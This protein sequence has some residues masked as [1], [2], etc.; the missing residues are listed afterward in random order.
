MR[1]LVAQGKPLAITGWGTATWRGAADVAPRSNEIV[2]Y[3]TATGA[4]VRLNGDY[5]RDEA[6]QAAYLAEQRS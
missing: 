6:S 2:E 5:V 4:P 3:D 1:D